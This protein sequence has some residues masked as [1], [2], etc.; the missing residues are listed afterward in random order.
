MNLLF[1]VAGAFALFVTICRVLVGIGA[2]LPIVGVVAAHADFCL[3]LA[4]GIAV[5]G[6]TRKLWVVIVAIAA[7][8]FLLVY[9]G[10]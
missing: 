4:A 5:A 1:K 9:V 3:G 10:L 8:Y 7:V 2:S 6:L